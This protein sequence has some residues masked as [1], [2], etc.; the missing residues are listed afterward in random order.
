MCVYVSII[1]CN[2]RNF[3]EGK[4]KCG[5]TPCGADGPDIRLPAYTRPHKVSLG[6]KF[7]LVPA[8]VLRSH[9]R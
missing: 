6:S 8:A 5:P 4:N 2:T 7:G 1:V 3:T 9:H